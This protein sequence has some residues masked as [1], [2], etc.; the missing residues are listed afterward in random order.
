MNK[1][2]QIC[3]VEALNDFLFSTNREAKVVSMDTLIRIAE[4]NDIALAP[5][6]VVS[7]D[8]KRVK[9]PFILLHNLDY[10]RGEGHFSLIL[11]KAML[12]SVYLGDIAYILAEN[13]IA[14]IA[15]KEGTVRYTVLN[16]EGAKRL[17]GSKKKTFF[18]KL[19]RGVGQAFR[20]PQNILPQVAMGM[21]P[22]VGPLLATGYGAWRGQREAR[23]AGTSRGMGALLGGVG[24]YGLGG[25]GAGL[26]GGVAGLTKGTGF[27]KGFGGG[28]G[29]YGKTTG[30][31]I[32]K[33]APYLGAGLLAGSTAVP[34]P[35]YP[36]L[37]DI[38]MMGERTRELLSET[39]GAELRT[40]AQEK[41]L[42]RIRA[43]LGSMYAPE[44][45]PYTKEAIR[46]NDEAFDAKE[47]QINQMFNYHGA[48]GTGEHREALE[49]NREE[50][51]RAQAQLEQEGLYRAQML[52]IDI[53]TAA[54]A[55]A[56]GVSESDARILLAMI[57][58]ENARQLGIYG[59]EAGTSAALQ[60]ML[61]ETGGK[62][63]ARG[64]YPEQRSM[65]DY[66][67]GKGYRSLLEGKA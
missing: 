44:V 24:G 6:A 59:E 27:L 67:L 10:G 4:D 18:G 28:W 19:V 55:T 2:A 25:L 48:F 52:D 47:E 41:L 22:G 11:D 1:I 49:A 60:E 53:K 16:R 32:T 38:G 64:L 21:I 15:D 43:P 17:R 36:E 51:Q 33:L 31:L 29:G 37:P 62:L 45:D 23:R 42:E 61:G 39:P 65:L 14:D 3:G 50:K 63:L 8:I 5:F 40:A 46:L 7:E 58:E 12:D 34:S 30:S 56:L 26:K 20:K 66:I 54:I 9:P 57:E 13:L 35:E